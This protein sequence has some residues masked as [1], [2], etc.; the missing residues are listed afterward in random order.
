M[1]DLVG[2]ANPLDEIDQQLDALFGMLNGL[3]DSGVS[4][5]LVPNLPD[6]G[7]IPENRGTGDQASASAVT[8]AWNDSLLARLF[9]LNNSTSADIYFLD[10]FSLFENL[11]ANPASEGFTNTTD[12]CRSVSFVIF[13]NE[14]NNSDQFVFWDEIHPKTAVHRILGRQAFD[15]ISSGNTL[16]KDTVSASAPT[17]IILFGF[18]LV[19]LVSAGKKRN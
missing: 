13:E 5:I 6:L 17:I 1:R 11:I 16:I 2:N 10:V 4:Q 7:F 19:G 9:D 15:L 18:G 12:E 3:L 8:Q 14:C